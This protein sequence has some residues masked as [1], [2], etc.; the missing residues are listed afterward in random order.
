MTITEEPE[1]QVTPIPFSVIPGYDIATVNGTQPTNLTAYVCYGTETGVYTMSTP[2]QQGKINYAPD[3]Q[4][5]NYIYNIVLQDVQEDASQEYFATVYFSD[6]TNTGELTWTQPGL[7]SQGTDGV[8]FANRNIE[9][10]A[11]IAQLANLAALRGWLYPDQWIAFQFLVQ[12]LRE[13]NSIVWA[14]GR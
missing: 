8:L 2:P 9:R 7:N 1:I 6:G 11:T 14:D 3:Q 5:Y 13:F 10:M 4:S 12:S